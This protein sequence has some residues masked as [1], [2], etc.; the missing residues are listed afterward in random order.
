M[1]HWTFLVF[2]IAETLFVHSPLSSSDS[3][4][5]E[6]RSIPPSLPT[7]YEKKLSFDIMFFMRQG[8]LGLLVAMV[9]QMLD[10]SEPV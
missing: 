2:F 9:T 6:L 10:F 4:P 7:P 5:V 3:T 1:W 8:V